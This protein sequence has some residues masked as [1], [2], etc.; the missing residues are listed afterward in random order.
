[1]SLSF[2]SSWDAPGDGNSQTGSRVPEFDGAPDSPHRRPHRPPRVRGAAEPRGW[3][4]NVGVIGAGRAGSVLGAALRRAG[5]PVTAV[6]ARSEASRA[7]AAAL[8][9]G[10][11]VSDPPRVARAAGLLV[12]AVA[13]D[14]L[15]WVV[16]ELAGQEALAPGATVVHVSG[17]SG[18]DV[19]APAISQGALGVALHPAMTFTGTT[20]DLDRIPGAFFGVTAGDGARQ[21]GEEIV[22]ALGGVAVPIDEQSRPLWHAGLAHGANHLVTLVSSAVDVLRAAG[23]PDPGAV[24]RPLLTAALDNALDQGDAALTGPVARGDAG[25]VARH[26]AVLAGRSPAERGIYLA[27]ARATAA[28]LPELTNPTLV[29]VLAD[30]T[31]SAAG[32]A[33][34]PT[35][36]PAP[37]AMRAA[38]AVRAA[39]AVS[40]MSAPQPPR[41]Y[42]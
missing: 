27:L 9:P 35:G 32:A 23:V 16:A 34:A 1:M 24:L 26:L 10:V 42:R 8:L 41:S 3:R 18:L 36:E 15:G 33:S 11:P 30:I 39:G 2:A 22:R 5:F 29:D 19:L 12:L 38:A 40:G 17:C 28:R 6:S 20:S 4:P 25:T 31:V 37:E 7:R 21:R 13:D 14:A